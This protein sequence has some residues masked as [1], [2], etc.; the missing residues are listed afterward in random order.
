MNGHITK[1][2]TK[3]R[4]YMD[5]NNVWA[6]TI[7]SQSKEIPGLRKLL[8]KAGDK[9]KLVETGDLAINDIFSKELLLQEKRNVVAIKADA[10]QRSFFMTLI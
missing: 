2:P 10:E 9:K 3:F 7:H 4:L 8:N 1:I 6:K 5:E